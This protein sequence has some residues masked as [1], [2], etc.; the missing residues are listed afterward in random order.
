L[1]KTWKHVKIQEIGENGQSN[2]S[3]LTVLLRNISFRDFA[4]SS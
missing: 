3:L 4:G 1:T 2:G